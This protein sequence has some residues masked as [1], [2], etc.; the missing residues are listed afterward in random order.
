MRKYLTFT[1]LKP[2]FKR[3][4][5]IALFCLLSFIGVSQAETSWV[6]GE[7]GIFYLGGLITA[8]DPQNLTEAVRKFDKRNLRKIRI[9]INSR[10]GELSA[11]IHLAQKMWL[12]QQE[13][14]EIETR[15]YGIVA[16]GA[17]LVLS[18]GSKGRRFLAPN[19]YLFYHHVNGETEGAKFAQ[20]R[21][22]K[23]LER[24]E[25]NYQPL[26][27]KVLEDKGKGI[28]FTAKRA[29]KLKIVDKLLFK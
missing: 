4:L 14:W 2:T 29:L 23:V 17:I 3:T 11:S 13:G 12:L 8:A 21:Y 24:N 19:S 20:E 6:E 18:S 9:I 27:D 1:S 10:G 26:M 7:T 25:V 22:N 5:F 28:Y 15:G 16:S